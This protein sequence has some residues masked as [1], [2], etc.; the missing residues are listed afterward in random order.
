MFDESLITDFL[1]LT[2]RKRVEGHRECHMSVL[3]LMR[4]GRPGIVPVD[5]VSAAGRFCPSRIE[6][7]FRAGAPGRPTGEKGGSRPWFFA[8]VNPRI[9]TLTVVTKETT[10]VPE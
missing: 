5:A 8:L 4:L 9:A 2:F 7:A 10:I 6:A 1:S 3:L